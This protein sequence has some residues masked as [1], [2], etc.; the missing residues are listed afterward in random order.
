MHKQRR[1]PP[2]VGLNWS[3]TDLSE[4]SCSRHII[5]Y[6]SRYAEKE[7]IRRR[8]RDVGHR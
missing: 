3:P 1:P 8:D 4:F 5:T 7:E 2:S 6:R